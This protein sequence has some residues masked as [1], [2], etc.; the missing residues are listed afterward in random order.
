M[1]TKYK[2]IITP[3]LGSLNCKQFKIILKYLTKNNIFKKVTALLYSG[4]VG[5][6]W[7]VYFVVI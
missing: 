3:G 2:C 5:V 4:A 6:K 1:F 7:R